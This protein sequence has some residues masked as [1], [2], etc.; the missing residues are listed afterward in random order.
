MHPDYQSKNDLV[1]LSKNGYIKIILP[2]F[3]C[4]IFVDSGFCRPT[5]DQWTLLASNMYFT[6]AGNVRCQD[7]SKI[8]PS[9]TLKVMEYDAMDDDVLY[10]MKLHNLNNNP[11]KAWWKSRFEVTEEVIDIHFLGALTAEVYYQF[12]NVCFDGQVVLAKPI[13][14]GAETNEYIL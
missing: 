8:L 4:F 1:E 7:G 13:V 12:E 11:Y 3:C 5:W 9:G 14:D 10:Q 6:F 2:R